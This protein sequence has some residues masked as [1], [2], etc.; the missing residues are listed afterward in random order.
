MKKIKIF[1][2]ACLLMLSVSAWAAQVDINTADAKT[3]S[4]ELIGVGMAKAQAIV[5]Y[6][7]AHGQ[8]SSLHDLKKVKGIGVKIIEMNKEKLVL[9]Q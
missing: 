9:K 2:T 8:F 1:F 3:L 4:M 6:R 7:K 5:D